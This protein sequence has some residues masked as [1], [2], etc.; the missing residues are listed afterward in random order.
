MNNIILEALDELGKALTDHNHVWTPE[1]R[2]LYEKAVDKAKSLELAC[3]SCK[4]QN[5]LHFNETNNLFH[6]DSCGMTGKL[7]EV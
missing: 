4:S 7:H 5:T 3:P 6:C 2:T 1:L